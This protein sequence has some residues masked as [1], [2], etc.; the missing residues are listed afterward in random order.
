M[1]KGK[2][3]EKHSQVPMSNWNKKVSFTRVDPVKR[4]IPYKLFQTSVK[5]KSVDTYLPL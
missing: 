1:K 4:R 3:K 5:T 2:K